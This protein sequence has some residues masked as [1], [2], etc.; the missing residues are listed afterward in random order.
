V[1]VL[2]L[3]GSGLLLGS[4]A[5]GEEA[6]SAAGKIEFVGKNALATAHGTFHDWQIVES[7]VAPNNPAGGFVVVEI[8]VASL[9]TDNRRRDDHL[10]SADF[11]DVERWPTARVRIHSASPDG[12]GYKAKFDIEIRDV[13]KTLDAV[14]EIVSREPVRVRGSVTLDRT[15]F[16]VGDPK[17]WNPMSITDEIPITFEVTLPAP[18]RSPE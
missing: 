16:G 2:L 13:K 14:F 6:S 5:T 10:R 4:L 15:D 8:D 11:F 7:Q 12:Y 1:F 18:A 9:D 3:L 17:S